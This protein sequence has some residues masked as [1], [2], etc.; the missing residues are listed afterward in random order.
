MGT[1]RQRHFQAGSRASA[2]ATQF[3]DQSSLVLFEREPA[4]LRTSKGRIAHGSVRDRELDPP[5]RGRQVE[6]VTASPVHPHKCPWLISR[7][8]SATTKRAGL[9]PPMSHCCESR[10]LGSVF[11]LRL[12]ISNP[13]VRLL[14]PRPQLDRLLAVTH[15]RGQTAHHDDVV[16]GTAKDRAE[17]GH[18]LGSAR[19]LWLAR[20]SPCLLGQLP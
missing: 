8:R 4:F 5:I 11:S 10:H 20:L 12:L 16:E 7:G 19:D 1:Q 13:P 9:L 2:T 6:E 18:G 15:C 14:T 17:R 3:L